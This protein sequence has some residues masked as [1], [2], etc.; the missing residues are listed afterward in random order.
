MFLQTVSDFF[1][2]LAQSILEYIYWAKVQVHLTCRLTCKIYSRNRKYNLICCLVG[3][4]SEADYKYIREFTKLPSS[5]FCIIHCSCLLFWVLRLRNKR[6]KSL[7]VATQQGDIFL[8]LCLVASSL[9][10]LSAQ[11]TT[12]S[13]G[14]FT[15]K[16][17]T[18]PPPFT[19]PIHPAIVFLLGHLSKVGSCRYVGKL[20]G[21]SSHSKVQMFLLSFPCFS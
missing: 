2:S 7:K 13:S 21:S 17:P 6:Q 8:D 15:A 10:T 1:H 11:S 20:R 5:L 16:P 14:I 12:L 3:V 19:P 4:H 18:P 9:P